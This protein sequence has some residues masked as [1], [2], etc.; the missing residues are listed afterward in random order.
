MLELKS[1]IKSV[2]KMTKGEEI[3]KTWESRQADGRYPSYVESMADLASLIDSCLVIPSSQLDH[4]K[5]IDYAK[6]V[7]DY[8]KPLSSSPS[9]FAALADD[10]DDG[11]N[12]SYEP[13]ARDLYREN[14]IKLREAGF[15]AY[16]CDMVDEFPRW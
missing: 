5:H 7:V 15:D 4:K 6:T 3:V 14:Q 16:N 11:P 9:R 12:Y 8:D 1:S 10:V 2:G 13:T